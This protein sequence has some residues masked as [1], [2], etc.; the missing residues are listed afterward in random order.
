MRSFKLL[1][2]VIFMLR[3]VSACQGD[4]IQAKISKELGIDIR[5]EVVVSHDDSHGGWHGDGVQNTVLYLS[6]ETVID[7]IRENWNPLPMSEV[8]MRLNEMGWTGTSYVIPPEVANGGYY[9]KDRHSEA[10]DPADDSGVHGR[11]SYNFTLAVFD[12]D[13]N[14]LYFVRVDT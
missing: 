12:A 1:L 5:E 7:Q 6:D 2:V 4:T 3:M 14:T 9:W 8:L 11:H 10:V 13:T